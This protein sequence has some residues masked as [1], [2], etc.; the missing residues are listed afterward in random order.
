[1]IFALLACGGVSDL[2]VVVSEDIPTVA[3]ISYSAPFETTVRFGVAGGRV[4]ETPVQPAFPVS[5]PLVGVPAYSTVEWAIL[6]EQGRERETGTYETGNLASDL[7]SIDVVGSGMEPFVA[8]SMIGTPNIASILDPDGNIVWWWVEERDLDVYRVRLAE[9]GSGVLFN[10]GSVSGDPAED[11]ELV[12]V[13]WDGSSVTTIPVQYLAHDFVEHEDGTIDTIAV[14]Y[15]DGAD[16]EPIRGDQI[17]EIAPDGTQTQLWSTW[18]CFDP[19]VTPGDDPELGWTFVNAL[20][21]DP[22]AD[23]FHISIRNF[24]SLVWIPRTGRTCDRILGGDLSDYEFDG[25]VFRHE[26]QF[27]VLP[28]G[29]VLVF[30]NDGLA[31]FA[32]RAIEY[33]LDDSTM[34]A[35]EVWDF[36]PE[37]PLFSFVLGDVARFDDGRTFVQFSVA[38]TMVLT[39]PDG[40]V[41]WQLTAPAPTAFGFASLYDSLYR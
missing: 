36:T 7:P 41:D 14:E 35:T 24:S 32:S 40:T 26:H 28:D 39:Q 8:T 9:D 5:V 15:R 17:L 21:Y 12:K 23:E 3:T 2:E 6:D 1:M 16:G 10:A 29:N 38:G 37:P 20:D 11:S 22:T 4:Y 33:E 19:E 25:D 34:T 30:D 18:D 27:E 13:S 31:S